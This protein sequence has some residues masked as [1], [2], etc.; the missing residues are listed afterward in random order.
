MLNFSKAARLIL[1]VTVSV[2]AVAQAPQVAPAPAAR[3]A[4][5]PA[6]TSTTGATPAPA[7][8]FARRVPAPNSQQF[9]TSDAPFRATPKPQPANNTQQTVVQPGGPQPATW[10]NAVPVQ[11]SVNVAVQPAVSAPVPAL[12]APQPSGVPPVLM[13][14][15][16]VNGSAHEGA[17]AV[18]YAHGQL[19]VVSQ[20]AP[21][22]L[23]LKLIAA[24][25]GA[26]VDLAPDLQ[27]EPVVAQLGPGPVREVLTAL[28]DSPRVD[29]IVMG[30]GDD[31]GSLQR[32]VVRTR[33]SFGRVAMADVRP[34][35]RPVEADQEPKVDAH[36]RL[37]NGL[38]PAEA[39]MTQEQL[40]ENWKKA[41]EEMRQAEIK[42]QAQD[43]ENEKTQPQTEPQPDPQPEPPQPDNPPSR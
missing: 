40:M 31:P 43:R 21:L 37:P 30:T 41:R 20:N 13:A 22:G 11:P 27:N 34:Q 1:A 35:P 25:T 8:R 15:A 3:P 28:L 32:I 36:G 24:K 2:L 9:T 19:T 42:Q 38:T 6:A 33:H 10:R 17:A 26:V 18:D 16:A 14:P 7:A 5:T 12:S 39:T 23:V 4:T 29:Y